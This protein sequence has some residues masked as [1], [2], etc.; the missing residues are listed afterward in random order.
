MAKRIQSLCVFC[1]SSPGANPEYA[2]IGRRLGHLLAERGIRLVY[3]GGNVGIMGLLADAALERGGEVIGIIPHALMQR[4]LAH[5]GLT[6]LHITNSMHERKALMAELSDGFIALPGGIGTLEELSEVLTW[7]QLGLHGKP[8]GLINTAQFYDAF[9]SFLDHAVAERFIRP[10][11]RSI[12]MI[13]EQP[14][15]LLDRMERYQPPVV[16][17][18]IDREET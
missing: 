10:E 7:A 17:K 18:W 6:E 5:N 1:G 3:G 9:V 8:C 15:A 13:E 2:A 11:H 14:E 16:E 4:E 12:L